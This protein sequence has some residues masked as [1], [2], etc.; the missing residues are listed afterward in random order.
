LRRTTDWTNILLTLALAG[1]VFYLL[2]ASSEEFQ[3]FA[4]LPVSTSLF[5]YCTL[6][7]AGILG[8]ATRGEGTTLRIILI[9]LM[10]FLPVA[11]YGGLLVWS[12]VFI[13]GPQFMDFFV[14]Q[15]LRKVI[16]YSA[17]VGMFGISGAAVGFIV[18]D[19]A[20]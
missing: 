2:I 17:L 1:L 3:S 20:S 15:A 8:F 9:A 12:W 6:L 11:V 5:H 7:G 16:M 10:L 18:G 14:L 19:R 4:P 13:G